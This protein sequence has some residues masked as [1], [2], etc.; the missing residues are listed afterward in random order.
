MRQLRWHRLGGLL[1]LAF[2]T[3]HLVNHVSAIFGTEIHISFMQILRKVYRHPIVEIPLLLVLAVQCVTGATNAWRQ[4]RTK[5][6]QPRLQMYSGIYLGL[7]LL[8]HVSAILT[9]R[10]ALHLDTNIFFAMAGLNTYPHVLFFVPYYGIAVVSF[11]IHLFP[12]LVRTPNRLGVKPDGLFKILTG[13]GLSTALVIFYAL[14]NGFHKASFPSDY[15][16][17]VGK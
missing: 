2:I 15:N 1:G 12:V 9:G 4:R 10:L 5:G 13:V 14:T 16:V 8:I 17:L 7:F 11:C 6:F 3:L